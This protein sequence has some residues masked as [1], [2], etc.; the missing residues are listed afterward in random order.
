MG[1]GYPSH[2]L[3]KQLNMELP[4]L[5]ELVATHGEKIL[6]VIGDG[7]NPMSDLG[8]VGQNLKINLTHH[9]RGWQKAVD[10]R[11]WPLCEHV[12]LL[13]RNALPVPAYEFIFHLARLNMLQAIVTTNYD[14][15]LDTMFLHFSREIPIPVLVNPV[16]KQ[17]EYDHQG[18]CTSKKRSAT[19]PLWKIH[20][21]LSHIFMRKC[22]TLFRCPD[23]ALSFDPSLILDYGCHPISHYFHPHVASCCPVTLPP[24]DVKDSL[25]EHYVHVM[26]WHIP[27]FKNQNVFQ[28]IIA[29]AMAEFQKPPFALIFIGFKGFW[30]PDPTDPTGWFEEINV[31]AEKL[32]GKGVQW[33]MLVSSEQ[34]EKIKGRK[35]PI[36]AGSHSHLWQIVQRNDGYYRMGDSGDLS[37]YLY[38]CLGIANLVRPLDLIKYH[39]FFENKYIPPEYFS[40]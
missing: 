4:E 28:R 8:E 25:C 30:P 29:G 37:S 11:F 1:R 33:A 39:L 15:T 3:L 21:S 14:L 9:R 26:D 18:Y 13:T 20:G 2:F 35:D 24:N 6:L 5:L 16:L 32:D 27:Q 7:I 17:R 31:E 34:D 38:D 19:L 10:S 36:R 22:Q 12:R 40:K 23:F